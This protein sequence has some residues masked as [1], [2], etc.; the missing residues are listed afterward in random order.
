MKSKRNSRRVR[1]KM[2]RI[3]FSAMKLNQKIFANF[4]RLP[5]IEQKAHLEKVQEYEKREIMKFRKFC[6]ERINRFTKDDKRKSLQFQPLSRI[7]R[8]VVW[9]PCILLPL[10]E[11]VFKWF[12]SSTG[13]ML[14]PS[15]ASLQWVLATKTSID[16]LLST[17][18]TLA[19]V[20]MKSSPDE[21]GNSGMTN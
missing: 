17:R 2:S 20:R 21:M 4:Y 16:T 18:K 5:Q 3:I 8:T 7:Y 12:N 10:N 19:R 6:E 1:R 15:L 9:V 13:M 11:N 14:P